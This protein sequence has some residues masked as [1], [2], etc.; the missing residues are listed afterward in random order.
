M[1]DDD[2]WADIIS[3]DSL[4][5]VLKGLEISRA[6]LNVNIDHVATVRNARGGSEPEPVTAALKAELAGASGIVCHLREDRRHVNDRD[7]KLLRTEG[8][9]LVW[10]PAVVD[11]YPEDYQTWIEVDKLSEMIQE[12]IENLRSKTL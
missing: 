4:T 9:D 7:L 10:M 1:L 6:V 8:T 12:H 3:T 5:T 11:M 2:G